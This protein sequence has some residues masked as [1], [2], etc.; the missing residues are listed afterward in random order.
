MAL[1]RGERTLIAALPA[2]G[3]AE[4]AHRWGRALSRETLDTLLCD[5]ARA[6]GAVVL[7][8]WAVQSIAGEPGRWRLALRAANDADAFDTDFALMSGELSK[9]LDDLVSALGGEKSTH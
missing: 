4:D 8:P 7:Q 9:L 1:M 2:A 3:E 5:A 6:A